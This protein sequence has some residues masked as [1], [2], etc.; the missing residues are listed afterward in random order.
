[1]AENASLYQIAQLGVEVTPGT[2]VNATRKLASISVTPKPEAEVNVFRPTGYKFATVAALN[3]EWGSHD[4]EGPLSYNELPY[5]LS[6]L[7]K[8]VTPTGAGADKTWTYTPSVSASDTRTTF[9]LEQGSPERAR[10][11]AYF[12]VS[13]LSLTFNR[14]G[15]ALKGTAISKALVDNQ[16]LTAGATA[17]DIV[18]VLPTQV[19]VYL[20]DTAAGLAGATALDRPFEVVWNLNNM[21]GPVWPLNAAVSGFAAH[22]DLA[23]E[24]AGSFRMAVDAAGMGPLANLRAGSTKFLRVKA[25]GGVLGASNY[26]LTVDTAMKIK[27]VNN[28][29]DEEGVYAIGWDF[30][31]AFDPTWTKGT[32]VVVVTNLTTL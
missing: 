15:C 6:S 17:L 25:V 19:S 23:P 18:P 1:M 20:A 11:F 16:A 32:E 7:I 10:D 28:L 29:S 2:A 30:E 9:T 3:K 31:T 13:G 5:L 27:A 8:T 12:L 24:A 4:L 21:S 26:S 22:V 14:D